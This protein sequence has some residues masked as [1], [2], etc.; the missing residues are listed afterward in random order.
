MWVYFYYHC[1]WD[2]TGPS[3]LNF[4]KIPIYC[5]LSHTTELCQEYARSMCSWRAL[6]YSHYWCSGHRTRL[7]LVWR[8]LLKCTQCGH[9]V[10]STN[11]SFQ[12]FCCYSSALLAIADTTICTMLDARH[13]NIRALISKFFIMY[14]HWYLC[15]MEI[16]SY[17]HLMWF[18]HPSYMV[19]VRTHKSR[20]STELWQ[21]L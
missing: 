14:R 11:S 10:Q 9:Q 5:S 19:W 4:P 2:H 1:S 18:L 8:T 17:I 21:Y 13:I 3:E 7:V 16:K 6:G 12:C 20:A 15:N